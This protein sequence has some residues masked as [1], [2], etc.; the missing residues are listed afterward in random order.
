MLDMRKRVLNTRPRARAPRAPL[1][2]LHDVVAAEHGNSKE[3]QN[4]RKIDSDVHVEIFESPELA[5]VMH[6]FRFF[7]KETKEFFR[8]Y[9]LKSISFAFFS[10]AF[11]DLIFWEDFGRIWQWIAG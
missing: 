2:R 5:P 8:F 9:F 7:P 3:F 11:F 10:F 1:P 6:F 4:P